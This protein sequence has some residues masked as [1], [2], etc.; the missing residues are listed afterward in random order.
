[1][2]LPAFLIRNLELVIRNFLRVERAED[3]TIYV[4]NNRKT[5]AICCGHAAASRSAAFSIYGFGAGCGGSGGLENIY[6]EKVTSIDNI[7]H[8]KCGNC[9]LNGVLIFE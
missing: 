4:C 7:Y 9:V 1:M 6:R 2:T 8:S 5:H 3:V